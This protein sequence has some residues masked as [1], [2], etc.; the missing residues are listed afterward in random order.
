MEGTLMIIS[1]ESKVLSKWNLVKCKCAVLTNI[2]DMFLVQCWRLETSSR[3]LYDFT[4]MTR[5][6]DLTI[7]NSWHLH[8][9][10]VLIHLLNKTKHW[11]L[12]I[13][14]YWVPGASCKIEKDLKLSPSHP[15]CSNDFWKF[16]PLFIYQLA[17]FRDLMSYSSNS[18][19][20]N[21]P[22]LMY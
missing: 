18:R 19:F 16:L 22:C 10:M 6:Q 20:K 9:K 21:T 1:F 2:S 11:N 8:F 15:N 4:I 3:P 7:F 12:Y 14:G 5:Y 17:K 13:I